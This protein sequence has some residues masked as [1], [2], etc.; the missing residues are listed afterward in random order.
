MSISYIPV[1]TRL[2][3]WGK[4]AGRC[5]YKGCNEPLYRDGLTQ[6]EFNEAYIAHIIADS[7]DGPR[8]DIE[9]SSKLN[10]SLSNLM[11]L[12]D[13]HHRLIDKIDVAGHPAEFLRQMKI[14]HEERIERITAISPDMH[15]HIVLYK[16]NIGAH[17][18]EL[19]YESVREFLLPT[20]YPAMPSAIDLGSSNNVQQD[21]TDLYWQT[22]IAN[23][24]GLFEEQLKP[25]LRRGEIKHL[26]LFAFAPQPL[27]IKLGSFLSDIHN[28]EIHQPIRDPKTWKWQD[29]TDS[30]EYQVIIPSNIS[31]VVAL[32]ISLSGTITNDRIQS[33][34][35]KDCSIYTMTIQ[36]PFNDYLKS[37]TQLQ[38]F[39]ICIRQLLD[40]IKTRH[41]QGT[42]LHVFPAMPIAIS[43]ELGRVW[44]PKADLP[45]VIYDQNTQVGGF[46]K[47][48]E[49][50][51]IK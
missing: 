22:E 18:P 17:T 3:L 40:Q 4:A 33:V 19:S 48:L 9:L 39:S 20:H 15:S 37:K 24:T 11:L 27:L 26:S 45:L 43:I 8:G 32:N 13:T 25:R 46:V 41:G 1:K 34:L 28:V 49:I 42:R 10:S 47:A 29:S 7:P 51:V 30:L 38:N 23:L 5:Q 35:G 50:G 2:L 44:M 12:C 36:T 6:T 16:A 31:S 21:K 14:E